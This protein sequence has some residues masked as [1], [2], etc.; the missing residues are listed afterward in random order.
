MN[1]FS[2][3]FKE[4]IIVL[5][6]IIIIFVIVLLSIT[7]FSTACLQVNDIRM[8]YHLI[9]QHFYILKKK[10]KPILFQF[11]IEKKYKANKILATASY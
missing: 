6:I 11:K 5:L 4:K 7:L 3:F 8:N 10:K 9:A 2:F 1:K